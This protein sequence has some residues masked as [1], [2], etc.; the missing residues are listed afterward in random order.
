MPRKKK[1]TIKISMEGRRILI[2][3]LNPA[4]V[5]H[6]GMGTFLVKY[7]PKEILIT[8]QAKAAILKCSQVNEA[9]LEFFRGNVLGWRS[10]LP[11]LLIPIKYVSVPDCVKQVIEKFDVA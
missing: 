3:T 10:T 1:H 2:E 9:G 4:R 6:H 7:C 8:R 11:K 5:S